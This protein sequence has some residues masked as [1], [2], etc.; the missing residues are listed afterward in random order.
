MITE[1]SRDGPE[2]V[3]VTHAVWGGVI[4]KKKEGCYVNIINTSHIIY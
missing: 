4:C 3:P 1:W 2:M